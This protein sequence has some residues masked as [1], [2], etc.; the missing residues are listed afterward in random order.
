MDVLRFDIS[1]DQKIIT[2]LLL[3]A[4][5]IDNLGLVHGKM[6]ISILFYHLPRK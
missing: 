5:F 2:A 3:N 6:G 1:T 4:S